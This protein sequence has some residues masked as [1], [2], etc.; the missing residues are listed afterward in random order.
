M[1]DNKYLNSV[2]QI[3][4]TQSQPAYSKMSAGT[5]W[6]ATMKDKKG[7][8]VLQPSHIITNA[9]VVNGAQG[10]FI[11]LPSLHKQDIQVSVVGIS[12]DL[13]IAVLQLSDDSMEQVQEVLKHTNSTIT[14]FRIGDSDRLI[15]ENFQNL[16]TLG[17][18]LGTE[19]QMKTYGN[20]SGLKHAAGLEQLYITSDAAINPGSSGGPFVHYDE[21]GEP[22]VYGMAD[23]S[24]W[25]RTRIHARSVEPN[26]TRLTISATIVRIRK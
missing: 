18:P 15:K 7:R 19:N 22:R 17:Y 26:K 21:H 20:Y 9:H 8:S 13:D 5:G 3:I 24:I 14:P 4:C 10:V 11:R 12:T 23:E 6:F 2:V 16:I 1:S 25:C